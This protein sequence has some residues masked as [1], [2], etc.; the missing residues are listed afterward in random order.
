MINLLIGALIPSKK[1]VIAKMALRAL[2]A[3]SLSC[4]MK[5]T[6]AGNN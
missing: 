3:A 1:S 6:I 2:L 4:C 5:A